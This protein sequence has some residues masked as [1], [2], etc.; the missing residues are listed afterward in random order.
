MPGLGTLINAAAILVGSTAGVAFGNRLPER[1]S[2][3]VTD[4]L[5]IVTLVSWV[6]AKAP[7]PITETLFPSVTLVSGL[8]PGAI[9]YA[10]LAI[11]MPVTPQGLPPI[12]RP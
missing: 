5:G 9:L 1:T 2:R 3:T 12:T 11:V 6:L 4:A 7:Q 8:F 10:V